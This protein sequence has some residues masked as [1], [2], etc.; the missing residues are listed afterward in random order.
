MIRAQ[1]PMVFL[2]ETWLVEA[3]IGE[4]KDRLLMGNYFGVL[5]AML[6]EHG[7]GHEHEDMEI[8]E[9]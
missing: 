9:K 3:R 1:D 7:H 8:F 5:K 6:H 4:I 2:A